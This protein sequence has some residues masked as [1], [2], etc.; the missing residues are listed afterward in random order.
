LR[1]RKQERVKSSIE[2]IMPEEAHDE[3]SEQ[4]TIQAPK[5]FTEI[6]SWGSDR[7]G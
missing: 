3:Y 4:V 6:F 5:E 1:I 2:D 7:H